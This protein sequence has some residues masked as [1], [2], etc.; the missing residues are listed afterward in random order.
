M[1]KLQG[2]ERGGRKVGANVNDGNAVGSKALFR[3][4]VQN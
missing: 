1:W 4:K 3:L 2:Y